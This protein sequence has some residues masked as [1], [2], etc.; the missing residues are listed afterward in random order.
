MAKKVDHVDENGDRFKYMTN[1]WVTT[2]C[3]VV[4]WVLVSMLNIYAIYDMAKNGV[5]G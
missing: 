2:V 4:V 5:S 1:N 3:A